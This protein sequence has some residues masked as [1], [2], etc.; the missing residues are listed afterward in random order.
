MHAVKVAAVGKGDVGIRRGRKPRLLRLAAG[1]SYE[2]LL[3]GPDICFVSSVW[4]CKI[5]NGVTVHY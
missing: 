5:L 1:G 4:I 3:H 2:V